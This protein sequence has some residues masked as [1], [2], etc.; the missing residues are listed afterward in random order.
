MAVRV[1]DS[2]TMALLAPTISREG[3]DEILAYIQSEIDAGRV[4]YVHCWGSKG[5]TYTVIGC[6]LIDG[7]LDYGAT[8]TE[9]ARLRAGT[10][11][12]HHPVPDTEAQKRVLRDRPALQEGDPAT[13]PTAP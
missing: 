10:K 3:Y 12:A 6:R 5:R 13:A 11:K 4:V 9:V 2:S 7:G 1:E 8:M